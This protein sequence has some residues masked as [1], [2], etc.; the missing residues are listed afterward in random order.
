MSPQASRPD[1]PDP[2]AALHAQLESIREHLLAEPNDA[3]A[4]ARAAATLQE[5]GRFDEAATHFERA[6]AALPT[7]AP[8]RRCDLLTQLGSC[9]AAAGAY[10][11]AERCCHAALAEAPDQA[12]PYLALG[13]LALEHGRTEKAERFYRVARELQPDHSEAH[14]ALAMIAQQA[15][16]YEEAFDLY[17]QSLRCDSDN[18]V[19][20]LGL[21]QTSCQMGDFSQIIHYLELY[22]AGHGNDAPVQFCLA[23]LYARQGRLEEAWNMTMQVLAAEPQKREVA[24]LL[25]QLEDALAEASCPWA[26]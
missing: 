7:D 20:L 10:A 11:E 21:F 25:A 5:L 14:A 8:S 4:L 9:R 26:D 12:G 2:A 22:L 1:G 24:E 16:R 6:L 19:A 18:L 23:T 3:D 13:M 15:E 17:L